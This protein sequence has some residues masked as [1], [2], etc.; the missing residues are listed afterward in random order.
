MDNRSNVLGNVDEE[1]WLAMS[2]FPS[3]KV[4]IGCY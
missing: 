1:N 3:V 2:N 4:E